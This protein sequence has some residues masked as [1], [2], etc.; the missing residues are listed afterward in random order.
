MNT[1]VVDASVVIKWFIPEGGSEAARELLAEDHVFHAPDF[2]FAEIGNVIWKKVRRGD[3]GADEASHLIADIGKVPLQ[4][5]SVRSLAADAL[6]VAIATRQTM[7]DALYLVLAVKLKSQF[8]T[9]DGRL[10]RSLAAT[11]ELA[12]HVQLLDSDA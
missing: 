1:L 2:V 5:V 3:L 8:I 12:H 9:A 4:T 10:F 7:Y 6:R 11:P